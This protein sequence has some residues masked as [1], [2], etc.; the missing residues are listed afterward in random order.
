MKKVFLFALTLVAS[1]LAFTA[2]NDK[3]KDE[4]TDEKAATNPIVGTWTWKTPVQDN[5]HSEYTVVFDE[6]NNFSYEDLYYQGGE[7]WDGQLK[8]GTYELDLE[9][10]IGT[11]HY[12]KA[13]IWGRGPTQ[14]NPLD[15]D[16]QIKYELSG[17]TLKVTRG[18]G[19]EHTWKQQFIKK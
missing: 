18:Y 3:K 5:Q 8:T 19:S 6:K 11:L 1:V 16:E 2:C 12:K 17:D 9:K 15:E 13:K 4:P 14:E 7:F 10:S